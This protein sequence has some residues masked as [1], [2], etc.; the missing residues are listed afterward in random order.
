MVS[1]DRAQSTQLGSALLEQQ[2]RA[3]RHRNRLAL[4]LICGIN[5]SGTMVGYRMLYT[6]HDVNI[7]V[8]TWMPGSQLSSLWYQ[9]CAGFL[10]SLEE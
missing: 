5:T 8:N 7:R 9:L 1:D 3:V 2:S 10:E 6:I 4:E